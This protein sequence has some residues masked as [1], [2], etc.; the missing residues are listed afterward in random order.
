MRM[1]T[2]SAGHGDRS[3]ERDKSAPTIAKSNAWFLAGFLEDGHT[4]EPLPIES[5]S[6]S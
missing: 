4:L 3:E 5:T 2:L 1:E 6:T